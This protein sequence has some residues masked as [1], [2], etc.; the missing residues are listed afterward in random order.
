MKI[1][2]SRMTLCKAPA[3]IPHEIY[4]RLE[5]E[6]VSLYKTP[7]ENAIDVM[8]VMA[9]YDRPCGEPAVAE[10]NPKGLK[11]PVCAWHQEQYNNVIAPYLRSEMS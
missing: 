11:I 10:V 3:R 9:E 7:E 4:D 6:L 1:V 8:M 5:A 2:L